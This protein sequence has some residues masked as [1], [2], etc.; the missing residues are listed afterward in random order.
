VAADPLANLSRLLLQLKLKAAPLAANGP[1]KAAQDCKKAAEAFSVAVSAAETG[2]PALQ[3]LLGQVRVTPIVEV[4]ADWECRNMGF[5]LGF[6]GCMHCLLTL[7][8]YREQTQVPLSFLT[9]P[10]SC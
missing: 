1:T 2:A 8:G 7:A 4:G 9:G 3:L 5:Q 10:S 6:H